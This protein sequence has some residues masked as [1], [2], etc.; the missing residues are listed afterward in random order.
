MTAI[1]RAIIELATRQYGV[2]SRKQAAALGATPRMIGYRL[3]N[4]I[5]TSL[6]TGIYGLPGA[7]ESWHR[8]QM[9]ACLWSK[10]AAGVRAAA[11][12]HHLPGFDHPPIEVVTETTRRPMPRSGVTV[13]HTKRLPRCQ[14]V[15]AQGIPATSIERT[16]FDLCGHV[17]SRQASIAVDHALRAGLT[18]IGGLD[19]CL[20]LTA[21]RGREGCAKLRRLIQDRAALRE[22]PNSPLETVTFNLLA[23]SGMKMPQ[24]Q[25]PLYDSSGFIGRPDFVWL[26]EKVVLEAHSFLWHDNELVKRSD[27]EKHDRLVAA[28]WRVLYATWVDVTTFGPTTLRL[29]EAAL[30]GSDTCGLTLSDVEKARPD[31]LQLTQNG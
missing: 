25:V 17:S 29:I 6:H 28:E 1:D 5:W 15:V 12:L 13:H 23:G 14:L 11:H 19:H 3:E 9:A 22:Y 2:F 4:G 27:R 24:L 30:N 10:G 18:S 7:P 26:D 31:V 8:S 16:L 21:R 20:Y